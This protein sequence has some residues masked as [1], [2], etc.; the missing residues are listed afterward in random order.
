ML[1]PTGMCNMRR[2]FETRR[3]KSVCWR[4][5]EYT[6][7]EMSQYLNSLSLCGSREV[8]PV[9]GNALDSSGARQQKGTKD[10]WKTRVVKAA[11]S[12]CNYSIIWQGMLWNALEQNGVALPPQYACIPQPHD[13]PF[14]PTYQRKEMPL[15]PVLSKFLPPFLVSK[16]KDFVLLRYTHWKIYFPELLISLSP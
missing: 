5:Q 15:I 1:W 3:G 12:F 16:H 14:Q 13:S 6:V 9:L 4:R 8:R 2:Y 10:T 7:K 11:K